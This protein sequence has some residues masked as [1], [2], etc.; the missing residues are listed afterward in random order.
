MGLVGNYELIIRLVM[1]KNVRYSYFRMARFLKY[2]A[3]RAEKDLDHLHVSRLMR[4]SLMTS[5]HCPDFPRASPVVRSPYRLAPYPV[6]V[7]TCRTSSKNSKR[8]YSTKSRTNG[9]QPVLLSRRKRL[10]RRECV[11][12]T[13]K[14]ARSPPETI[15]DLLKTENV[16]A[17]NFF[18][19]R[20][21]VLKEVQILDM[22]STERRVI[23]TDHEEVSQYISPQKEVEYAP[24]PVDRAS[25][26]YEFE[27]TNHPG[28]ANVVADA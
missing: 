15:L 17:P 20:I 14:E 10:F 28:N 1:R 22:W 5:Q 19:V 6:N 25:S 4:K 23:Y 24:K 18:K 13:Q 11:L 12:T 7:R 16:V 21:L 27:I 26:D 8:V 9:E 3:E 2:K